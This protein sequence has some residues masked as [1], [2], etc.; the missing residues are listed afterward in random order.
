[1]AHPQ[2]SSPQFASPTG[3]FAGSVGSPI[4]WPMCIKFPNC[5]RGSTAFSLCLEMVFLGLFFPLYF[6]EMGLHCPGS[7]ELRAQ[8]TY[9]GKSYPITA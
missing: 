2:L 7:S 1:M 3:V 4:A 9:T 8:P 5:K 6:M